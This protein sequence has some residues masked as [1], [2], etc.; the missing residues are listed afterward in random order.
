MNFEMDFQFENSKMKEDVQY[1]KSDARVLN[2]WSFRDP[3]TCVFCI[4]CLYCGAQFEFKG[5]RIRVKRIRWGLEYQYSFET[6]C[7]ICVHLCDI[8]DV[9]TK[10]QKRCLYSIG[11]GVRG[12]NN[13][14]D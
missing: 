11:G 8:N 3:L 10:W 4:T 9:L 1:L 14:D 7:P 6:D 5:T 2:L 13:R 12:C